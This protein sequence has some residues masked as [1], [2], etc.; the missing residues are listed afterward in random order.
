M[1]CE[2]VFNIKL[3]QPENKAVKSEQNYLNGMYISQPKKRDNV[4]R[5]SV[6][7]DLSL[8][9]STRPNIRKVE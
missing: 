3:P 5:P 6:K 9:K 1:A 7:V 8:K 4:N 2:S